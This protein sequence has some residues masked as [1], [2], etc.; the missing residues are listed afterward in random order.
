MKTLL[1]ALLVAGTLFGCRN[2]YEP[3]KPVPSTLLS[4]EVPL[5]PA[6]SSAA[7]DLLAAPALE[8][9]FS[10]KGGCTDSVVGFI[11]SAKTEV[12]VLAYSFTSKPIIAALIAQASKTKPI[13]DRM[14]LGSP[15]TQQLI[16]AG[17]PV[18]ID[19]KHA[20]AHNKV[21]IVDRKYLETGSFNFTQQAETSNAENCVIIRNRVMAQEF[22]ANWLLHQSHSVPP[23]V[24]DAGVFD[25]GLK[26]AEHLEQ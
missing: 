17:I 11:T 3:T 12:L 8:V 18:L 9:H 16:A 26:S 20:I 6:M 4:T 24:A 15:Q 13:F 10:P 2:A 19:S 22:A 14:D 25:A 5:V 21:I 23:S 1:F 7:P